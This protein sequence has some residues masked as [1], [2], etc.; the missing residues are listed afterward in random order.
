MAE[1]GGP[2]LDLET[3]TGKKTNC[4]IGRDHCNQIPTFRI[5]ADA[6]NSGALVLAILVCG[7][8]TDRSASQPDVDLED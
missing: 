6:S 1:L 4:S 7:G 8:N 3:N 2:R 5:G